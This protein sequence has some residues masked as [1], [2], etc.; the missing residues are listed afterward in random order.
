[1]VVRHQDL[2]EVQMSNDQRPDRVSISFG[3]TKNSTSKSVAQKQKQLSTDTQEATTQNIL[4]NPTFNFAGGSGT[5]VN[6][7]VAG[8]NA[9]AQTGT[10]VLDSNSTTVSFTNATGINLVAN[11]Y[12]AMLLDVAGSYVAIAVIS[13][14]N[15]ITPTTVPPVTLNTSYP[16]RTDNLTNPITAGY[17]GNQFVTYDVTGNFGLGTGLIVGPPSSG[18]STANAFDSI[19]GISYGLGSVGGPLNYLSLSGVLFTSS[20]GQSTL[21]YRN[22]YSGTTTQISTNNS[23]IVIDS[24]NGNLW[25]NRQATSPY[26][27]VIPNGTVTPV[28]GTTTSPGASRPI[29]SAG[30]GYVHSILGNNVYVKTSNAYDDWTTIWSSSSA[31][32]AGVRASGPNG[33]LYVAWESGGYIMINIYFNNIVTTYNTGLDGTLSSGYVGVHDMKVSS[34]NVLYMLICQRADILGTG[35]SSENGMAIYGC[36]VN[37]SDPLNPTFA[38]TVQVYT[39][40]AM[41]RANPF[42]IFGNS[43]QT[44][45]TNTLIWQHT[46]TTVSA[47]SRIYALT[48]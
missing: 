40:S 46:N 11:D 15:R 48:I 37:T 29:V 8:Y 2:L 30:N 27:F 9:T 32:V 12:I 25:I 10:V 28:A 7:T 41:N 22:T 23:Q 1:M 26:T 24:S 31:P 20:L 43:L 19:N 44:V 21:S 33:E 16:I 47:E 42:Y 17:V 13:R 14:A 3:P 34:S 45:G 38:P 5:M 39:D 6:G 18:V 4:N 36:I 35:T